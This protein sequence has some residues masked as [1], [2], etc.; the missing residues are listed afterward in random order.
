MSYHGSWFITA[1]EALWPHRISC[2]PVL[3]S[4]MEWPAV[5]PLPGAGA[6]LLGGPVSHS[7]SQRSFSITLYSA[8]IL[9][10]LLLFSALWS[11]HWTQRILTELLSPRSWSC[12]PIAYV[13]CLFVR[14][15]FCFFPTPCLH[16]QQASTPVYFLPDHLQESLTFTE[17]LSYCSPI[18]I[19]TCSKVWD[20][21]TILG[22]HSVQGW[23]QLQISTSPPALSSKV[24]D[25]AGVRRVKRT[26]QIPSK[27]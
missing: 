19:S 11:R 6:M 2:P 27:F 16:V 10:F 4:T 12:S 8:D 24:G 23:L 25:W 1:T 15:C 20:T 14:F 17:W 13:L 9:H 5:W 21:A 22:I 26:G 7:M 18:I 3:L